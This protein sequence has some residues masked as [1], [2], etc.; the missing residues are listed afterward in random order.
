[1][2]LD[3]FCG[4]LSV[5]GHRGRFLSKTKKPVRRFDP[6]ANAIAQDG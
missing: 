1:L 2:K 5:E 3:G 6:L 4:T